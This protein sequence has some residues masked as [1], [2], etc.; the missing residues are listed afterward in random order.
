MSEI[1]AFITVDVPFERTPE[2]AKRYLA[3]QRRDEGDAIVPLQLQVGDLTVERD[4]RLNVA[5]ARRYPGYEVMD[6]RWHA[7]GGGPYPAFRGTLSAEQ[8]GRTYC[9][10]E[11]DGGY[12]PPGSIAGAAFDAVIGKGIAEAGARALLERFKI[13]F[14][15]EYAAEIIAP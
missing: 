15:A 7:D 3:A 6:I 5:P 12:E 14:E 2:L 4:V 1:H 9:R 10:L 8:G 11:L 13:A